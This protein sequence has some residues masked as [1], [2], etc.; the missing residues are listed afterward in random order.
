MASAI[1]PAPPER[2]DALRH[3]VVLGHPAP[4]SLN[5][6][7]AETYCSAVRA[8]GQDATLRDLYALGFDPLLRDGERPGTPDV[9]LPE[10]VATELALLRAADA[11][12][13]VYPI[14]FGMPPAIIKGYVDRVLGAGFRPDD[15]K[16]QRPHPVLAGKRL[17]I[18]STSA[19][20]R[21]WLDEQGQWESLRQ[22]F[23][24]Y[25]VATFQMH[26]CRHVHFDAV[27]D[28]LASRTVYEHLEEVRAAAA[29]LC[30]ALAQEAHARRAQAALA[31]YAATR[32]L[33][34]DA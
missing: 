25:L 26:S 30:G 2:A 33:P 10:D 8:C 31:R 6:A 12:V 7:I 11:L 27:V 22:T 1:V 20:T 16:H 28:A 24:R 19:T 34:A 21:P 9:G 5:R 32:D 17:V 18:F 3:L 29:D 14:W 4:S 13:L 23:E 15:L